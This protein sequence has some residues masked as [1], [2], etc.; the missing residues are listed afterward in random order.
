MHCLSPERNPQKYCILFFIFFNIFCLALHRNLP[1]T[2]TV[3]NHSPLFKL[4]RSRGRQS[5]WHKSCS[6]GLGQCWAVGSLIDKLL[7]CLPGHRSP[8]GQTCSRCKKEPWR[9]LRGAI[10]DWTC[11]TQKPVRGSACLQRVLFQSRTTR[12]HT[13]YTK[14]SIRSLCQ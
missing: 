4:K 12:N 9:M 3:C 10:R 2:N 11:N 1:S 5:C 14:A 7:P 8:D 13:S 6:P